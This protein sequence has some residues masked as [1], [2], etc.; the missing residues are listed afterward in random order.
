MSFFENIIHKSREE[1]RASR[2]GIS[3]IS[4]KLSLTI[5]NNTQ[6]ISIVLLLSEGGGPLVVHNLLPVNGWL[7]LVER[8]LELLVAWE[9]A[10]VRVVQVLG[11]TEDQRVIKLVELVMRE[12]HVIFNAIAVGIS[13]SSFPGLSRFLDLQEL[14]IFWALNVIYQEGEFASCASGS[15]HLYV[16]GIDVIQR[17]IHRL[18]LLRQAH[19]IDFIA[20]GIGLSHCLRL[21]RGSLSLRLSLLSLLGLLLRSWHLCLCT[22]RRHRLGR[23]A[24]PDMA[25]ILSIVRVVHIF[26]GR[27]EDLSPKFIEL[28]LRLLLVILD[29]IAI[30]I[31]D[32]ALGLLLLRSWRRC[33]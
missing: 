26:H 14:K 27:A 1:C 15:C 32:V 7:S 18:S 30:L 6:H 11:D 8:E 3:N 17:K 5:L 19:N 12:L 20:I 33:G 29:A 25:R 22:L 16:F 2:S 31:D 4:P 10:V 21:L 13:D 28:T 23:L 9:V 24:C